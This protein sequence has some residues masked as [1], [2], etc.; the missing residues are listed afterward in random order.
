M[1]ERFAEGDLVFNER[2]GTGHV[3][4]DAGATVIV[5]FEHGL[6]EC[7]RGSLQHL[8]TPLQAIELAEWHAPI[9]V[10]TR[11]QAEAIVSVNDMWGV[12]ALSRIALLPHQLWV[13]RRVLET[14]PTRWLVA[15]DVG[16]GKTIE[17]GLI[18]SPLLSRNK[19]QRLLVLC[20]ASLVD[21]WQYRL[22]TMF[23]IRLTPYHPELDKPMADFWNSHSQVVASLQTLRTDWHDRHQRLF[24][25][26]PWDLVM[27][28]E[29]HH[30]NADEKGGP[31]L[32][33]QLVQRL[34]E[35][36]RIRSMVFFTG[37]PHR[38]KN[39]G[40]LALLQLLRPD[41]FDPQR[42]LAGQLPH[43]GEVMIRNNKQNVTDLKGQRL[44]KPPLVSS[45][46]YA[47]TPAEANFYDM[48]TEFIVTGRA[49]ASTRSQEEGRTI[50]LVL[51]AMQKLASSSVAAIRRSLKGRLARI[52]S[53][54]QN[55][56]ALQQRRDEIRARL[57]NYDE[58]AYWQAEEE[59]N[60]LDEELIQ[61]SDTLTL[62]ANEEPRLRELTDAAE[63]V[64]EETK[65]NKILS[66][67]KERFP[68]Q[69]VLFFTEYTATQSLLMSA[70]MK[71]YGDDCVTFINGQD[72]ADAVVDNTGYVRTLR[73]DRE[74]ATSKFNGG[75]ARFLVSTEAGGEGIDLQERC[76]TLIHVDLPWN[77]M[78]LH[79][80]VGRLNRYGQKEQVQVVTLRNPDTVEALIWDKLNAKIESIKMAFDEVM[81]EPEDLLQLVLGM[82]SPSF[83]REIF[84]EAHGVR[85]D[86][87][88]SWFNQKTAR[89]GDRDAVETVR[90]LVG[91][92]SRFDFQQVSDRLPQVD[93]PALRPFLLSMLSL[94]GRRVR[95]DQ[96][97]L[98]FLTP[99]SW[100][101]E[102]G[103]QSSYTGMV[104]DRQIPGKNGVRRILGVGHKVVNQAISV[105]RSGAASVAAV[106]SDTLPKPLFVFRLFDKVTAEHGAIRTSVAAVE[107]DSEQ[108]GVTQL[109]QD[110]RLLER[111]N[112][113]SER[114]G[115]R[116]LRSSEPPA[117][118]RP[119]YAASQKARE[120]LETHLAEL[121]LPFRIPAIEAWAVLWPAAGTSAASRTEV[122]DTPSDDEEA[123]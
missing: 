41:V 36:R 122:G 39:Y 21:Q 22:R 77:P 46:T 18:L 6:E 17:A 83:F 27:V 42:P 26:E 5:R 60:R 117:D 43:L 51:I 104:F 99:D 108:A 103:I 50:I 96:D 69:R 30:L 55:A 47:Y 34:Q 61:L 73:E 13:C 59:L 93:L 118:L 45:E 86:S 113:L 84:G 109:L 62:M 37:T 9:E 94:G 66:I 111:L 82:A 88:A 85:R 16:L 2:Y 4:M 53:S 11:A 54:R 14:W 44:F 48:L 35:E 49:Y 25:S 81:D 72:R 121:D 57:A 95:E 97:G 114:K 10:I 80:R 87:L 67:L 20:P 65:I 90:D 64:A 112:A 29:A 63:Q 28:D 33:Y 7:E 116:R 102:P 92:C 8:Y 58:A 89:F 120:F 106:P 110:W 56:N 32:G 52:Q 70:L 15:D 23:D 38:G 31:T 71:Q 3:R 19:V 107:I 68:G 75:Q 1:T 79:Q 115:I 76:H 91:N 105:A 119:V 12:F 40:F 123:D 78:R 24:D 74:T 100:L 98:S 101:V